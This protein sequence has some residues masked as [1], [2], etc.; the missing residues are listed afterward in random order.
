M[1][2]R[3]VNNIAFSVNNDQRLQSR[4]KVTQPEKKRVDTEQEKT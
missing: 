4:K 3:K 1:F 2:T